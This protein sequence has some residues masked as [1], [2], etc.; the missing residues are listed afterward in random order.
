M[1]YESENPFSGFTL[2]FFPKN[3]GKVSVEHGEIFHEII[4]VMEKRYQGKWT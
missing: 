3:L 2:G 4:M 1:Q